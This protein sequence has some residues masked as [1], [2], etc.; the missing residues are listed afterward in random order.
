M[1]DER[2]YASPEQRLYADW[3]D[4]GTKLGFVVLLATFVVHVLELVPPGIALEH[5]PRYWHLP[6]DEFLRLTGAPAGWE[7]VARLGEG[8]LLNFVGVAILALVTVVCYARVL[9]RFAR[10]GSRVFVAICAAEIVVLAAAAWG[11]FGAGH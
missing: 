2:D 5:L 10:A 4:V 11:L 6:V 7:W 3:L 9:P 1:A 8:D